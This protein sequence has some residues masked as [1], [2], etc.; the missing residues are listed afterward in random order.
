MYR[1]VNRHIGAAGWLA[2]IA[3]PQFLAKSGPRKGC[4]FWNTVY[5]ELRV[6]LRTLTSFIFAVNFSSTFLAV[7]SVTYV[8]EVN[9]WSAKRQYYA[10][11]YPMVQTMW[12]NVKFSCSQLES[13]SFVAV[14]ATYVLF[15]TNDNKK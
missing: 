14:Y 7:F 13:N 1:K 6:S 9:P 5:Y 3:N 11:V 15:L 4:R 2:R 8:F 12:A 10:H